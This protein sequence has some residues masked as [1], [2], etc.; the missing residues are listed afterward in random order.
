MH[1]L[2]KG[3]AMKS[4]LLRR[5]CAACLLG[6][7]S[8]LSSGHAQSERRSFD[9]DMTLEETVKWVGQR[10][11]NARRDISPD[12]KDV[13]RVETRLVKARGCTLNYW[14]TTEAEGAD[15]VSPGYQKRELWTLDLRGLDAA[16][17]NGLPSGQVWFWA[18]RASR[19]S[20]RTVVYQNGT[21]VTRHGNRKMGHFTA[22]DQADAEEIAAALRHAV[23]LCQQS[24]Q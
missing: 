3:Q 2:R 21:V 10:L 4:R 22:R 8:T 7:A 14:S 15:P 23:E 1:Y 18:S 12:R 6:A 11:P 16:R 20:I 9:A 24:G 5:L 17:I 13:W 19:D